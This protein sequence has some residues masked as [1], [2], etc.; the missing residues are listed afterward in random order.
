MNRQNINKLQRGE[1]LCSANWHVNAASAA[2]IFFC[3]N[4]RLSHIKITM[5]GEARS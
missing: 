5:K 4:R 3:S 2:A 1:Q